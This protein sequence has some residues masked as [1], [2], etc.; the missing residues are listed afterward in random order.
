MDTPKSNVNKF[1]KIIVDFLVNTCQ[2]IKIYDASVKKEF[3]IS[4]NIVTLMNDRD[5]TQHI[6]G[7][8][9]PTAHF[10]A[11]LVFFFFFLQKF[12]KNH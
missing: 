9:G 4:I 7:L 12:L 11:C 6:N 8:P 1:N 2:N 3:E 10:N 5:S